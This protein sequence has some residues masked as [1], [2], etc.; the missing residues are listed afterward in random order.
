MFKMIV[1]LFLMS[2]CT[3]CGP[4][5]LFVSGNGATN[6]TNGLN[7]SNGHSAAFS[8]LAADSTVC[9]TGGTVLSAGVDLNDNQVL[10]V[11]ETK[12]V[13][14]TCNGQTGA[15][16]ATGATGS[17]GSA[18]TNGVD[19]TPVTL[20]QLCPGVSNYGTFIELGVC[21]NNKLYGVYSLNNGFMTYFANGSYSS[22][23]VG[24]ACN[25]TVNGCTVTH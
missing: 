23:A 20:V 18:G 16:G 10:E 15:T 24:S 22:N 8:E 3:G 6:G 5:S 14:I 1:V 13:V 12:Q 2:L 19:A 4:G 7:G 17:Q 11:S 9:P 25:L 21:L